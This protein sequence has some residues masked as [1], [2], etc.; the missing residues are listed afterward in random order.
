[1]K[2]IELGTTYMDACYKLLREIWFAPNHESKDAF[3]DDGETGIFIERDGYV[4]VKQTIRRGNMKREDM[5]QY[6]FHDMFDKF[7]NKWWPSLDK[8]KIWIK[9]KSTEKDKNMKW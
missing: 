8:K 7:S 2:E 9:S 3:Q 5:F 1:M 4:T 6:C